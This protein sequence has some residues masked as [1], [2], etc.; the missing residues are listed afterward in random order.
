MTHFVTAAFDD[1]LAAQEAFNRL[2][3]AGFGTGDISVLVSD[4]AAGRHFGIREKT[5]APEGAAAGAA[6]GGTLGA[7][8]AGLVAVGSIA[9]PGIGLLAAGPVVAAL[10]GAGAGGATG[11]LL[12][13]AIGATQPEHEAKLVGSLQRGNILLAV[14]AEGPAADKAKKILTECGA[15]HVSRAA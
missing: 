14:A 15:E 13:A 3:A 2:I 5:K 1:R 9:L 7:L 12:G 10:A 4:H 8:V 11:G 6:I